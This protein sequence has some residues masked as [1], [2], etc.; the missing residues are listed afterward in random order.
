MKS[1][2]Q[3]RMHEIVTEIMHTVTH[4]IDISATSLPREDLIH[5][6]LSAMLAATGS[7]MLVY[8]ETCGKPIEEVI[9]NWSATLATAIIDTENAL[10]DPDLNVIHIWDRKK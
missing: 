4:E 6:C 8:A 2:E 9:R 3:K 10:K 1:I 7:M 5:E